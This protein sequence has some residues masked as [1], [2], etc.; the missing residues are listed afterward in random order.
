M[1]VLAQAVYKAPGQQQH[2]RC[3]TQEFVAADGSP[4]EDDWSRTFYE[5]LPDLRALLPGVLLQPSGNSEEAKARS[6]ATKDSAANASADASAD[7]HGGDD[8]GRKDAAAAVVQGEASERG[9]SAEEERAGAGVPAEL[10]AVLASLPT[11]VGLT[12]AVVHRH[13]CMRCM[14]CLF[15]S[16]CCTA[17]VRRLSSVMTHALHFAKRLVQTRHHGVD[18][19]VH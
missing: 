11:C 19:R 12:L 8:S 14:V 7:A 5:T 6:S 13:D 3:I 9:V 15:S 17:G 18:L 4:F 16:T 1:R 2:M 10:Q